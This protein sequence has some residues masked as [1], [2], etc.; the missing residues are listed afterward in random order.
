MNVVLLTGASQGIGLATAEHLGRAGYKVYATCRDP[1]KA[2]DLKALAQEVSNITILNLDV[3][4][5]LSV[6]TAIDH[7]MNKEG[8]IDVV[9]NNAGFGI[10]GPAETQSLKEIKHV[11]NTNLFGV[12][13]VTHKVAPIMRNQM[14]GRIINI[15][16]ISGAIPSKNMPIY[17]CS[18]A[19]LESL[20]ATYAYHFAK[21]GILMALVQPGPVV[22]SFEPRTD[23]GKRFKCL[24]KNPYADVLNQDRAVWKKMMDGGQTPLEVAKIIQEIIESPQ[25]QLWNPTSQAVKD[26]FSKQYTD[27]TGAIRIPQR[28]QPI[29][30]KL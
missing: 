27:I 24:E 22:T 2:K 29:Q 23:F 15:G 9:I 30:S 19:A 13:R 25:P 17:S 28:A 5:K 26:A 21:W 6:K 18:K 12:I 10:Y 11:F 3:T 16:S 4:S 7:V 20:T 8:A 1:E 14:Q